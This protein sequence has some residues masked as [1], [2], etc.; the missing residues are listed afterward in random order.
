MVILTKEGQKIPSHILL[1][2]SRNGSLLNIRIIWS[3]ISGPPCL[4]FHEHKVEAV[5]HLGSNNLSTE[6]NAFTIT[7]STKQIQKTEWCGSMLVWPPS[8]EKEPRM[9]GRE[10]REYEKDEGRGWIKRYYNIS[11]KEKTMKLVQ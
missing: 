7:F 5:P 4:L 3:F 11:K 2:K 6:I 8:Q 10:R 9:W 1:C